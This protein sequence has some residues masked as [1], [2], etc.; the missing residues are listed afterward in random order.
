MEQ[1]VFVTHLMHIRFGNRQFNAGTGVSWFDNVIREGW[2]ALPGQDWV[3]WFD[4]R[5]GDPG[6]FDHQIGRDPNVK[7]YNISKVWLFNYLTSLR[8]VNAPGYP[9]AGVDDFGTAAA[10]YWGLICATGTE[11]IPAPGYLHGPGYVPTKPSWASPST[12]AWSDA[13]NQSKLNALGAQVDG[14]SLAF[15]GAVRRGAR[16]DIPNKGGHGDSNNNSYV[17]IDTRADVPVWQALLPTS[18]VFANDTPYYPDG[19]P[20]ARHLS[21]DGVYLSAINEIML[22][23]GWGSWPNASASWNNLDIYNPVTNTWAAEGAVS[24]IAGLHAN[25]ASNSVCT[26]RI[27]NAYVWNIGTGGKLRKIDRLTKAV[28]VLYGDGPSPVVLPTYDI[29]MFYDPP[30]NRLV[31]INGASSYYFS[32]TTNT[33]TAFSTTATKT[34]SAFYCDDIDAYMYKAFGSSQIKSIDPTT[35]AVT[36]LTVTGTPPTE[37]VAGFYTYGRFDYDWVT[38]QVSY[39]SLVSENLRAFWTR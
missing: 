18:T 2:Y 24:S 34:A 13:G 37:G 27:G 12:F 8:D 19:R 38:G 5:P 15:T 1:E 33:L 31:L 29:P 14:G 10:N 25:G 3:K 17:S 23:G 28:T 21:W 4:M 7:N 36:D 16:L 20:A 30:R 22:L 11:G 6:Y 9:I 35:F 32:L 39:V 26:D